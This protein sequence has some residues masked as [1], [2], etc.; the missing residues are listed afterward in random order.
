M[1]KDEVRVSL[2]LALLTDHTWRPRYDE[3]DQ[4]YRM[5]ARG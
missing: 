1:N 2:M 4:V 5:A 3:K